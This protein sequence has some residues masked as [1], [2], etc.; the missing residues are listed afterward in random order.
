MAKIQTIC[1]MKTPALRSFLAQQLQRYEYETVNGQNFMF[2]Q[3]RIPVCLVAHIDT[4]HKTPPRDVFYDQ[5]KRV[6]WSPDGLGADD[7][8]GVW[9]I[10]RILGKGYRPSVLFTDLEESGCIGAAEAAK[11]VCPVGL[12]Y[13]VEID[14]RGFQDAVFYEEANAKFK[15]YVESFGFKEEFGSYTDICELMDAWGVACV[16]VSAGYYNEHTGS[17]HLYLDDLMM[18][19]ERVMNM[20]SD[21]PNAPAFEHVEDE[22]RA[23][24]KWY[25][26]HGK[27]V[28]GQG[29][30]SSY[31]EATEGYHS[32]FYDKKQN[33]WVD[34]DDPMH[35]MVQCAWCNAWCAPEEAYVYTDKDEG[36]MIVCSDCGTYLRSAGDEGDIRNF[37]YGKKPIPG[38]AGL[39]KNKKGSDTK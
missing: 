39:F 30:M 4:V 6:M 26:H 5:K 21:S 1:K 15:R 8:A 25:K 36:E 37:E 29:Y 7:R 14:R 23:W 2:A 31:S 16:N 19:I 18:T 9:A 20:L 22:S 3:G 12:K 24:V 17:E 13:V 27:G 32:W 38:Q 33:V 10:L 34:E 35:V 11:K 28:S